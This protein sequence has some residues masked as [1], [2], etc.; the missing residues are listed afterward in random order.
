MD[1]MK[2]G[3]LDI[4]LPFIARHLCVEGITIANRLKG[5]VPDDDYLKYFEKF[6]IQHNKLLMDIVEKGAPILGFD[7][8]DASKFPEELVDET[9]LREIFAKYT[10]SAEYLDSAMEDSPDEKD[11]RN[12]ANILRYI[13]EIQTLEANALATEDIDYVS[14]MATI[15]PHIFALHKLLVAINAVPSQAQVFA[16]NL[17]RKRV[18]RQGGAAKANRITELRELVLQ[19]ANEFHQSISATTAAKAIFKKLSEQGTWML[20]ENGKALLRDAEMRFT[21]WIRASRKQNSA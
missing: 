17:K 19:E 21:A 18:A 7:P 4:A 10:N 9:A 6:N 11:L 3:N 14:F 2:L 8:F 12:S 1:T 15:S 16:T 5:N 20:D 13:V